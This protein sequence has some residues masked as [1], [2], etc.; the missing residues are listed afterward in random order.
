MP[1]VTAF[2]RRLMRINMLIL[3]HSAL[4]ILYIFCCYGFPFAQLSVDFK[5]IIKKYRHVYSMYDFSHQKDIIK[6]SSG[7]KALHSCVYY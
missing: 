3:L 4:I 6:V 7:F 2:E 1:R 5:K